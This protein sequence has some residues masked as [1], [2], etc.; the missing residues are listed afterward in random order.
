MTQAAAIGGWQL[1]CVFRRTS[2]APSPFRSDI[3]TSPMPAKRGAICK[4]GS[5]RASGP[6]VVDFLLFDVHSFSFCFFFAIRS[7]ESSGGP[8]VN[9]G[10]CQTLKG[11]RLRQKRSACRRSSGRSRRQSAHKRLVKSASRCC[12][13]TQDSAE[14]WEKYGLVDASEL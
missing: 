1:A 4:V 7:R 2:L 8:S 14:R 6:C 11:E 10:A 13:P 9:L 12:P 3:S 5:R